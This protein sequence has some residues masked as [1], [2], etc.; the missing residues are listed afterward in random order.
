M[1]SSDKVSNQFA[2]FACRMSFHTKLESKK[3]SA[4]H[5][6]PV[7]AAAGKRCLLVPAA[8]S[9]AGNLFVFFDHHA[10]TGSSCSRWMLAL[11][12]VFRTEYLRTSRCQALPLTDKCT[13][14]I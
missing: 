2:H 6:G 4:H 12:R 10:G 1:P 13:G 11:G 14:Y 5:P 9:A 8:T 3:K 7:P